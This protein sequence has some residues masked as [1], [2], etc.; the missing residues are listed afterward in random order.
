M[1][2]GM[3]KILPILAGALAL[4]TPARAQIAG[5]VG[6]GE[7]PSCPDAGGNHLNYT[8]ATGVF[9]CGTTG[10]GPP[11]ANDTVLG[12]ASGGT[13]NATALGPAQLT[14][15]VQPFAP[16]LSGAV[17]ASGGGT[18][19][20][21]RADG[22]W[23][24]P[25]AGSGGAVPAIV[26]SQVVAITGGPLTVPLSVAPTPG[27]MLLFVGTKWSTSPSILAGWTTLW[28]DPEETDDGLLVLDRF[29]VPG[30][31][32]SI[33][34]STQSSGWAGC[35]F[36]VSGVGPGNMISVREG[37]NYSGGGTAISVAAGFPD[38]NTQIVGIVLAEAGASE[39]TV[40]L[41]G[42]TQGQAAW[43]LGSGSTNGG[44]RFVVSF[45]SGLLPKGG[46]TIGAGFSAS[47]TG[48]NIVGLVAISPVR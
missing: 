42:A 39:P 32:S 20:F 23:A 47:A 37:N 18:T 10:N 9:S 40:T 29:A 7:V 17:P 45:A 26:Q 8:P 38:D 11:I 2:F 14:A 25:P 27:D 36:E 34:V 15:L 30:D 5:P 31:T 43:E 22:T 46:T 19:T 1:V 6:H 44:N 28:S 33:Q 41:T 13:A 21:L 4:A 24:M 3:K 48:T 16:G 35:L 12:N